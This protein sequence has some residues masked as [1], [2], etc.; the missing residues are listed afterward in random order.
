[1]TEYWKVHISNFNYFISYILNKYKYFV[2]RYG[3]NITDN[4]YS[5]KQY[6]LGEYEDNYLYLCPTWTSASR[7]RLRALLRACRPPRCWHPRA[8]RR[9]VVQPVIAG[10]VPGGQGWRLMPALHRLPHRRCPCRGTASSNTKFS[11]NLRNICGFKTRPPGHLVLL[12]T[13]TG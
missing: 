5:F 3:D 1:M 11:S 8:W 2:D 13:S 12:L 10:R 9:M 4:L 7:C 6:Y